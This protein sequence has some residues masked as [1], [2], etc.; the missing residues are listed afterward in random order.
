MRLHLPEGELVA[1][2]RSVGRDATQAWG[3]QLSDVEGAARFL[4]V[5]L[6]GSPAT[7]QAD[8]SGW[9][10]LDGAGFEPLPPWGARRPGGA[11][12]ARPA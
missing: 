11:E 6:D 12:T 5:W 1:L 7:R 3:E 9:W 2:L 4:S 8:P 10:T